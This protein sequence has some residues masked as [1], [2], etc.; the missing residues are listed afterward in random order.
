MIVGDFTAK[1][2]AYGTERK[3]NRIKSFRESLI[4]KQ[5]E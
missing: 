3:N 2:R 5:I 4:C 1:N